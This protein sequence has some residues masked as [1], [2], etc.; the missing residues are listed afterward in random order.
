MDRALDHDFRF[1]S[2]IANK[3]DRNGESKRGHRGETN[4]TT[5]DDW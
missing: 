1:A 2:T 4:T 5:A 3:V